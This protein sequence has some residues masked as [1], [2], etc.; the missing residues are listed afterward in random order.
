MTLDQVVSNPLDDKTCDYCSEQTGQ[1]IALL[2][3]FPPFDYCQNR[4]NE[5]GCRCSGVTPKEA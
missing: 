1:I 5:I 3:D 4:D 2:D